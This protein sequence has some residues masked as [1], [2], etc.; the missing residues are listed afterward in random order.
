M[1]KWGLSMQEGLISR[2][3]KQE[4]DAVSQGEP[5]LEVETEKMTNL[6]EAPAGG[7][8]ARILFPAGSTV[9]VTQAIALIAQPG[10][11]L[12]EP[13]APASAS[14]SAAA[15]AVGESSPAV[16]G[17][18]A[19]AAAGEPPQTVAV[20]AAAATSA[21][22][23]PAGPIRAMPAARRLAAEHGLDL[24][25]LVGSGPQGAIT[26]EDVEH[27]LQVLRP[28]RV[29]PPVQKVNFYSDGIR[30]DGM[31]YT[32]ED[33]G[34][35]ERRA[36]VVLLAGFTYLK[37]LLLPDI[38][39]MLTAAGYPALVFDYR[40]FGDSDGPRWRLLPSD[41]VADA[42][43]A[44][45]FLADQPQVDP[46]RLLLVGVSL[47][48]ANAIAAGAMDPRV[49]A[50]VTISSPGNGGRWLRSLRRYWEWDE[51]LARLAADR[52]R[53]VRSGES[54][55]ANP[56]EIVPPDP[57]SESFFERMYTEFPD[58][59]CEL[60]L[61]TAEALI[62]FRPEE[63]VA[64]LAPRPLLLIHGTAD[65]LVP[66]DEARALFERA[67]S[68]RQLELL[69]GIGHFD[70]VMPGSHGFNEVTGRVVRFLT[71]VVPAR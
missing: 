27:A 47:G 45:T 13:V 14:E 67:G 16:A 17:Q 69:P 22:P 44:L 57:E 9:P 58:M 18:S 66:P 3:L 31:L 7:V 43:A 37:S 54:T 24:S 21:P 48:G 6:V 53:R 34:P 63:Q 1:P 8:L 29:A 52:S 20:G 40:G 15:V 68:P 59:R 64:R 28:A 61:E 41:Q 32:P 71:E 23:R 5:V 26:R 4:G 70:W 38:A 30:L 25:K 62:E 33:L 65:R 19:A 49:A 11:A 50:V 51:F 55:R 56:L 10:E 36:A 39:R 2:W 35:G 60:P 42:R 46:Q 12:P